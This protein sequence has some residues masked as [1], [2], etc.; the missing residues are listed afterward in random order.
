[1]SKALFRIVLTAS[2]FTLAA[3]FYF[4]GEWVGVRLMNSE[5]FG[6]LRVVAATCWLAAIVI[7]CTEIVIARIDR[8]ERHAAERRQSEVVG[9]AARKERHEAEATIALLGASRPRLPVQ[10][11]GVLTSVD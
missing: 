5:V 7:R 6:T 10:R 3:I 4:V 1:M 11:H 9:E 8:I 2:L